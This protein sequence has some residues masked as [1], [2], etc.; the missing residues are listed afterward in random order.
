VGTPSGRSVESKTAPRAVTP[1]WSDPRAADGSGGRFIVAV[2][3]WRRFL[4]LGHNAFARRLGI[5]HAYWHQL[6]TGERVVSRQF[7]ERVLAE[8]PDLRHALSEDFARRK[9]GAPSTR[10]PPHGT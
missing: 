3:H 10:R 7:A 2:E 6:R 5:S 1:S 9:G 4:R 8:R